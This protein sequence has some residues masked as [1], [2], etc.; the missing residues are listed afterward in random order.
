MV[1]KPQ[2]MTP[3]S[4][5]YSTRKGILPISWND[6]H[7]LVKAL[8][9]AVAPWRPEIILP[10][11]R[12]GAYPGALLAQILQVE[13]YPVRLSRRENDVVVHESPRW[14]VE[15]PPVVAGR[16]VLV[17]DEM[18][19][20]GET[21]TLVRQRALALGAA[22]A[23]AAVLYAH[24]WG[25]AVPDYIGL[26]TDELVLNPWDREIFTDGA[27]RFHPEYV[28][29]LTQQGVAADSSLLVPTTQFI[30]QKVS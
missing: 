23:R 9:V 2:P 10:V 8:A 5:D 22:E 17:V 14:L 27:F 6:F 26:I 4:Y 12:G 20:T 18:C 13:V 24:T 11:L 25:V 15:P 21:I 28:T 1:D 3:T 30:A 16:R 7:G 19:S 29:A